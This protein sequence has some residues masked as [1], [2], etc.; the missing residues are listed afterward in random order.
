M[1]I[2]IGRR[3]FIV[4]LFGGA[5]AAWALTA[6]AQQSDRMRR[7]GA[8]LGGLTDDPMLQQLGA[9]FRESFAKLAWTEGRNL[10]IDV[11]WLAGDPSRIHA[12]VADFVAMTP[13]HLLTNNNPIT[14][15]LQ[16]QKCTI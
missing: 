14:Q 10:R 3:E 7:V 13:K 8:L 16:S 12:A 2:H 4:T 1:A 5:A 6:L 11:R 15:E 9:A